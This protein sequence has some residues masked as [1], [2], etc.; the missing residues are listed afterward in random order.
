[1]KANPEGANNNTYFPSKSIKNVP[2]I[3]LKNRV[4]NSFNAPH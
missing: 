1:M 2:I 4:K 3:A